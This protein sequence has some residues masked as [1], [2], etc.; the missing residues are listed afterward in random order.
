MSNSKIVSLFS[1]VNESTARPTSVSLS[2]IVR[3]SSGTSTNS[4]SQL[5]L[6]FMVL[7]LIQESQIVLEI[8]LDVVDVVLQ[9]GVTFDAAA[10]RK[11]RVFLGV[12]VHERVE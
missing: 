4:F 12:V 6:I 7:E 9:H 11:A 3:G 2:P 5:K 10:E 1:D 8:E